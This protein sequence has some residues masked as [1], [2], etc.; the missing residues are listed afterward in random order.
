M[1]PDTK[2][3]H[4]TVPAAAA[5]GS[6]GRTAAPERSE[7]GWTAVGDA[8]YDLIRRRRPDCAA[9]VF[10]VWYVLAREA[11]ARRSL[12]F[13]LA[14]AIVADRACCARRTAIKARL[15]LAEL[16]LLRFRQKRS[17][18]LGNEPTEYELCPSVL[19]VRG[20][21]PPCAT[22]AQPPCASHG[23]A[24]DAHTLRVQIDENTSICTDKR[25]RSDGARDSG[26]HARSGGLEE[27]KT[28]TGAGPVDRAVPAFM[29]RSA[30]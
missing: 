24:S 2:I 5:D 29:K 16:R 17:P 20:G 10:A 4:E 18:R 9:T 8:D 28:Q 13:S 27:E 22:V 7:G 15:A 19:P 12:K 30:L 6:P 14:D 23:G 26:C 3:E 1:G 11:R 25:A 21:R